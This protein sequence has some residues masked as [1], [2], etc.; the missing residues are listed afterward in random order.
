MKHEMQARYPAPADVVIRMMTDREF[1]TRRLERLGTSRYRVL[2]HAF[3]GQDFRIRIERHVPV[4]MPGLKGGAETVVVNEERWNVATR[5]GSVVVEAGGMPV[6]MSCTTRIAD[7]GDGCVLRF[8]WDIDASIPLVGKTLEKFIV[9]DMEQR[10]EGET[11]A[12]ISLL[13]A[14]R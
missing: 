13:D 2:E 11:A 12:G 7:D 6:Q 14:Y 5:A 4:R 3:D 9:A 10:A 8:D 1:H